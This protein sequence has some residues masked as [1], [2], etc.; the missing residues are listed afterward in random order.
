[1]RTVLFI[2]TLKLVMVVFSR[3]RIRDPTLIKSNNMFYACL[4]SAILWYFQRDA[5]G[6]Y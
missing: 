5:A 6:L 2:E 4:I 3:P 1:M